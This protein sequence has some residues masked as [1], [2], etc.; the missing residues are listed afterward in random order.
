V[1][2]I[3]VWELLILLIVH[4]T[5]YIAIAIYHILCRIFQHSTVLMFYEYKRI[6]F[7]QYNYDKIFNYLTTK[8]YLLSKK[9]FNLIRC[10]IFLYYTKTIFRFILL[11]VPTH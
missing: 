6:F 4:S 9:I 7:F 3:L 1:Y 2:I 10:I 5:Q 8:K 11:M